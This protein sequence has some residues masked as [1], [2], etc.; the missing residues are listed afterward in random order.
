M[1]INQLLLFEFDMEMEKTRR[2]LERVPL[3]KSEWAPHARSMKLGRLAQHV[4]EIPGW[5]VP[6]LQQ[7]ELSLDGYEPEPPPRS[8]AELLASFDKNVTAART[9]LAAAKDD[10]AFGKIWT[11]KSGGKAMFSAPRAGVVRGFVLNHMIHHRGQLSVYLRLNDIPV[12]S[13]Y[14]PSADEGAF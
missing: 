9:A 6:T 10:A 13:I 5:L 8:G 2:V 7:D 3:D 12:P 1:P 11:L 4:A 14:G